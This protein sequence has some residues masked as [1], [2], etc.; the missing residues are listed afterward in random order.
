MFSILLDVINSTKECIAETNNA[1]RSINTEVED[2]LLENKETMGIVVEDI[3]P[4]QEE[5]LQSFNETLDTLLTE[6][7]P[8][9]M[10]E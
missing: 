9:L 3:I 4:S 8:E 6:V 5:Q 2:T 7:L 10:G 1:Q